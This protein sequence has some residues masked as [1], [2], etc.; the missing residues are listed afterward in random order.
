MWP[1]TRKPKPI[2]PGR[3][4]E[5]WRVGD[6]AECLN[7][8]GW[9]DSDTDEPDQTGPELG[10]VHKV[11]GISDRIAKCGGWYLDLKGFP[12]EWFVAT[13][14]RKVPLLNT[15]ATAEFTAQIKA[16]RPKKVRT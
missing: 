9:S 15:A 7:D 5:D 8:K 3:I 14:F 2:D 1:F 16:I 12:G 13:S 11:I 4:N 10:D 6:L